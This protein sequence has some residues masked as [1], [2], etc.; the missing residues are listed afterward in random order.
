M[1]HH[2]T[3]ATL[4]RYGVCQRPR[5]GP[6]DA[7]I[8]GRKSDKDSRKAVMDHRCPIRPT[9]TTPMQQ[10]EEAFTA[11]EFK[12]TLLQLI[13]GKSA[14]HDGIS[15][16]LL[17]HLSTKGS[18]LI[19]TILSRSWLS[20]R[21]PQSCCFSYVVTFIKKKNPT[22]VESYRPIAL[23]STKGKVLERFIAN[24]MSWRLEEH[25]TLSPW[26]VEYRMET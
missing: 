3:V 7:D 22:G 17:K 1:S 23:T 26:Q 25:S 19:L 18:L 8:N 6:R 10:I 15:P 11:G 14:D 9:R 2:W 5:V 12:K 20:S 13:D 4:Q 16:D 21:C 24:C